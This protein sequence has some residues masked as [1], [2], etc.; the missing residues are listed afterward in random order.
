MFVKKEKTACGKKPHLISSRN[1]A[2]QA[3]WG[4]YVWCV[5]QMLYSNP[6]FAQAW[7]HHAYGQFMDRAM[8][9]LGEHWAVNVD[10]TAWDAHISREL[11]AVEQYVF[12]GL[13]GVH[14]PPTDLFEA[15]SH[16]DCRYRSGRHIRLHYQRFSGDMH[17]SLGNGILNYVIIRAMLL[18]LGLSDVDTDFAVKGDDSDLRLLRAPDVGYVRRHFERC[19]H[20]AKVKLCHAEDSEFA[21]VIYLQSKM[22]WEGF[23]LP[24]K[25]LFRAPFSVGKLAPLQSRRRAMAVAECELV[26]NSGCPVIG[27]LA[28]YWHRYAASFTRVCDFDTDLD[29]RFKRAVRR[30]LPDDVTR[31]S[32]ERV[33]GVSVSM[34]LE[35]ESLLDELVAGEPIPSHPGWDVIFMA[36]NDM[37]DYDDSSRLIGSWA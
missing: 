21:S 6:H 36:Y 34:Q 13:L 3:L 37:T 26:E 25:T 32:F 24:Y 19:G 10:A 11:L 12:R 30:A 8:R 4:P 23:R 33:T 9:K 1:Q 7:N 27:S 14:C 18:D 2:M 22:G 35:M 16:G 20:I 31:S 28:A 29:F 15:L 17:T 5:E